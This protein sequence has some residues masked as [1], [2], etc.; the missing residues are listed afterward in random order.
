MN[1]YHADGQKR[2][3][4]LGLSLAAGLWGALTLVQRLSRRSRPSPL[5]ELDGRTR[6]A[7][8]TG[9]SSGIGAA[10][11]RRLA[12]Q[13]FNLVLVARR[14]ERLRAMATEL[15]RKY[16]I[17]TEVLVAD[18]SGTAGIERVEKRVGE[19]EDLALLINNAGF[20][21]SGDFAETDIHDHLNM[22]QV[23]VVASARLTRA[24]LPGMIARG[25]GAVINV[26]SVVGFAPI[27]GH[28]TYSATKAYLIFFSAAL[29]A[30]LR[31]TGVQVQA[32]CPG[33][34]RTEFHDKLD[35]KKFDRTAIPGVLWMNADDVAALSLAALSGGQ[36]VYVPSQ[37]YR[38]V[39]AAIRFIPPPLI[40][41]ARGIYAR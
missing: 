41:L 40:Q 16:S 18:L 39:A 30:E 22:I 15:E 26:S 3:L 35:E 17:H 14:E 24:A 32:L 19:L 27:P 7:L 28:A 10:F 20:G 11:A 36:A 38:L 6:T 9:S 31:G 34:T 12:A 1:P 13:G 23:H 33:F 8:I 21:A 29:H 25:R 37:M 5:L 4:L 2:A